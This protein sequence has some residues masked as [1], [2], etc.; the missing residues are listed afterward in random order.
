MKKQI[1]TLL[2]TVVL[3]PLA[4]SAQNLSGY[5]EYNEFLNAHPAQQKLTKALVDSVE[6]APV[7]L[8]A[9]Q[10]KPIQIS[11]VYP[12]Q[13][14]SDYWVRNIKAFEKRLDKL[15]IQYEINQVFTRPSLDI[16]QQSL[17]LMEA[18]KNAPDYLVFT[19]DTTRHRKFIEHVL[20]SSETK[21]ILQNITTPVRAWNNNQPFM[22]VGFDHATGSRMLA[23]Y[24]DERVEEKGSYS[25]LYRSQGYVSDARGDTFIEKMS[26]QDNY[27]LASSYYTQANKGSSYSATLNILER[28]PEIEF[29]Y[30]CSTDV[31]LGAIEALKESNRED[32]LINGWGGGSAELESIKEGGLDVTV[33]RMNDD[34]GIAM[35]DAIK[36]DIEGKPVPTTYSGDFELVT[37][38]DTPERIELLKQRAFRY[39]D[40]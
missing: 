19:L 29:I 12:G 25:V 26:H 2:V 10:T 8:V 6:S 30:A 13:Q 24:F 37:Q 1:T 4:Q 22:Y 15:G 11:V 20:N 5:W 31:A 7:P 9:E 23:D 40:N 33:M 21:L 38:D 34:T 27:K 35:A 17:S 18:V 39:S 32:V 36:W 3:S 28:N 14:I 16:R